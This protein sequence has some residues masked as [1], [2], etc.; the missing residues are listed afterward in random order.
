M[1][2][3]EPTGKF[4]RFGIVLHTMAENYLKFGRLPT[5]NSLAPKSDETRAALS[6]LG[7]I[8]HTPPPTL[9]GLRVETE[10]HYE[11]EGVHYTGFKDYWAPL[12]AAERTTL[13]GDHKTTGDLKRAPTSSA[14]AG[15]MERTLYAWD[16]I[17][18]GAKGVHLNWVYMLRGERAAFPSRAFLESAQAYAQMRGVNE[19]GKTIIKLLQAPPDVRT[20][21]TNGAACRAFGESCPHLSYCHVTVE[22]RLGGIMSNQNPFAGPPAAPGGLDALMGAFAPPPAA[23]VIAPG[24]GAPPP[25]PV[26]N[27]ASSFVAPPPAP[28]AINPPPAPLPE[29]SPNA[30]YAVEWQGKRFE[31]P[32]TQVPVAMGQGAQFLGLVAPPAPTAAPPAPAAPG[33]APGKGPR[34]PRT[35]RVEAGAVPVPA[36]LADGGDKFDEMLS[37][38]RDAIDSYLS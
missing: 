12:S 29:I 7:G 16:D 4:A 31:I 13:C 36:G 14:L 8:P 32:G 27:V 6:L 35:P 10:F 19:I 23:P 20:M 9:P 25:P 33:R 26:A 11:F 15:G 3:R 17:R 22:Q 1:H 38:I 30:I 5:P 2:R 34:K 37:S 24:Y 21:A 28:A 18:L